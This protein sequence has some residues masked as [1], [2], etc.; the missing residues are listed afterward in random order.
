MTEGLFDNR[1][2]YD[3]IYPRGRSGETL[4]AVDT[5]DGDRPVV[6]K[7]PAPQDAPPIRAGQEV[8]IL[9]ERRAL[10]KLAGQP[11]LTALLGSGQFTIGGV[12]HQYIVMERATGEIL[13]EMVSGLAAQGG[14]LPELEMLVIID[15]LLELLEAAH[16]QDIVYNDVDAKHLFWDREAY[17][18]KVID[19][20]NAVF[21]EG[22]ETTPQGVSRQSDVYQ[23][24]ELLYFIVTGG[25]RV[26]IS[27]QAAQNAAEEFRLAF[28]E[29]AERLHSRLQLII[30]R[31][32]HP[33]P[34][35][36]HPSLSELRRELTEYRTPVER[37]RAAVLTRV[38][39]RLR[40]E[41]SRDELFSLLRMM[42]AVLSADPG[43]PPARQ[44]EREVQA[45]MS[46]LQ[47][48][49][50]LD[51]ARIYLESGS[52]ARALSV[53]EELRQRAR[54]ETALLI[55][56]LVDWATLLSEG[57]SGP[58]GVPRPA[59]QE[60]IGLLFE[61]DAPEAA[62]VLLT[63][64]DGDDRALATQWLL[65]ERI[66]AHLPEIMLLRPN[67]YRLQVALANLA[68]ENVM[69]SEPRALLN[70]I[71]AALDSLTGSTRHTVIALRDGF[72]TVVDQLTGLLHMLDSLNA[73][74]HLPNRMLPITALT[75]ATNAAMA[76][77]D[78]MHV[79]GKQA[80]G[81][82]R[83]ALGALDHCRQIV[84]S[85]PAWD[86]VALELDSLY[87][88]L[89]AY[90][91]FV[92]AADGSDIGGWIDIA[93]DTLE[94]FSAGLFDERLAQMVAGLAQAHDLWAQYDLAALQGS[95]ADALLLLER[96]TEALGP[97]SPSLVGWLGQLRAVVASSAYVERNALYGA[98]GRALADGWEHFD[99]G[100]LSEAERLGLQALEAAQGD[101][102]RSAARRLRDLAQ[103]TREWLE[104]GG[105]LDAGRTQQALTA[106]ELLYT[107][108]EIGQRD[109]FAAQMPSKETYLKV[110]GRGLIEPLARIGTAP[111]RLFF[112]NAVFYGALDAR[113]NAMEDA[114]FWR[115][116]AARALGEAGARHVLTR[117]LEEYVQQR[118]DLEAAQALF[119]TLNSPAALLQL[120]RSRRALE[121]NPQSRL[122]APALH[123]LRELEAALRDW[124][125][126]E[127]RAAGAKLENAIH[128][129]DEVE[130]NAHIT[131]TAYRA[132]LMSL[133]QAA[134]ELHGNARRLLQLVEALPE[135]ADGA[136]GEAHR[137]AVEVTQRVLGEPYVGTLQQWR[138]MYEMFSGVYAD[139]SLRRSARLNRL[140]D[141][142]GA[143]FIERHPAYPL[144][145]HWYALTEQAPEF[146]A[147]P[148][149][150]PLPRLSAEVEPAPEPAAPDLSAYQRPR[151]RGRGWLLAGLLVL[152][153]A[154]GGL[155]LASRAG[156][157]VEIALTRALATATGAELALLSQTD[158]VALNPTSAPTDPPAPTET[159]SPAAPSPT[160][161]ALLATIP[162]RGSDTATF[163]AT[164]SA[165]PSPT[166]SRTPTPSATPTASPSATVTPSPTLPPAGLQGDQDLLRFAA[167]VEDP[168]WSAEAFAPAAEPGV[169]ELGSG[170]GSGGD[171]LRVA[172]SAQAFE[173]RYGGAAATRVVRAQTELVLQSFNPPLLVDDSVF[174]GMLLQHAEDPAQAVGIQINLVE[175]DVIR[176]S[177]VSGDEITPVSQRARD[178]RP[179]RIRIDRNLANQ[180]VQV[181]VN[182][183]PF[184]PPVPFVDAETP[185]LP[186]LYVHDGG[187]IV[188][189][190]AWEVRLQ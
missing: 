96:M 47:V 174:F 135:A 107:P 158:A 131:L 16:T 147:P 128:A 76:L 101:F 133:L 51:A 45:R 40:R 102:E 152:G 173:A 177:L 185:V 63:S 94:P 79:I 140:N 28:G 155:A 184:G 146:P 8:S 141:F 80:T 46:D 119:A 170:L 157:P 113:E 144:Y 175:P 121:E 178:S 24:G 129:V 77:A 189:V 86:A 180:A 93:R 105:M 72:R 55:T 4:R 106:V 39:D 7:R 60:A 122:L 163:T 70:E 17:R 23:V 166:V 127:F 150:E 75:R 187:V 98:L 134:A 95:R 27:R 54:G 167:E 26:E 186:V 171:V 87:S 132:W 143:M 115:D 25:G 1:Y 118:R 50:D 111:V 159:A 137:R 67:L 30:S 110:M 154:G 136:L 176:L 156:A 3:Y 179:L 169:W 6:I 43:F 57:S 34:R 108:D 91:E 31:A 37:D 29:D 116:V 85:A 109:S 182:D 120:D 114:L 100:R 103:I 49:A 172:P 168:G 84:P 162:P 104:R 59:V 82:P 32:V 19:W 160:P 99:R 83:E 130:Q 138:Q 66:S 41:L 35:Y 48:S 53:L 88:T 22:E 52:W 117:A 78:N 126:G 89:S 11:A 62:R 5:R 14:R 151:R 92:P 181:L 90:Q 188:Y 18:L 161:L 36:R 9:T 65:A 74:Y 2:R 21:L 123:S 164:P 64:G 71:N 125:D 56:L 33:N 68:A 44:T 149:S 153:L 20:G 12:A 183:Q 13:A 58:T 42:D 81:S 124:T 190:T 165:T 112:A 148:T 10:Q 142:F 145:R 139:R 38:T 15:G 61:D 69:V 97:I 73:N